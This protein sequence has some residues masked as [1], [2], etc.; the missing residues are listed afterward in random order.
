MGPSGLHSVW[1]YCF[2]W[3]KAGVIGERLVKAD[4]SS[5]RTSCH[6]IVA[7]RLNCSLVSRIIPVAKAGPVVN[8]HAQSERA[9]TYCAGHKQ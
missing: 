1:G 8:A 3:S 9:I 2:I 4:C 7:S 6:R 5:A